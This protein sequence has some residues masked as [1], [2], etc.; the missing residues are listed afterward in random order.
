MG[1]KPLN[2]NPNSEAQKTQ[3]IHDQ[4]TLAF[5][6]V[7]RSLENF[8]IQT[9][10]LVYNGEDSRFKAIMKDGKMVAVLGSDYQVLPN[11]TAM[12]AARTVAKAVE[13]EPFKPKWASSHNVFSESG[14]RLFAMYVMK[15]SHTIIGGEKI[16]TGFTIQNGIDGTLAFSCSGF[17][18]RHMCSNG[19]MIGYHKLEQ[20][21]RKHTSGFAVNAEAIEVAVRQVL[22]Q[23]EVTLDNYVKLDKIKLNQRVAKEIAE[24]RLISRK[25]IPSYIETKKNKLVDFDDTVTQWQV[26]NDITKEIWHNPTTGIDSKRVQFKILHNII[27]V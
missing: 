17:T 7:D 11:Q 19:S 13:A 5:G 20:F 2:K 16:S 4:C 22:A 1:K 24:N 23:M 6:A 21:Y 3:T 14:T 8:G 9:A 26:Y 25:V 15:D 27:R 18:F 10:P 12:A